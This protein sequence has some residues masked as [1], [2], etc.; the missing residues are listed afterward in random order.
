M[1]EEKRLNKYHPAVMRKNGLSG[2]AVNEENADNL[3]ECTQEALVMAGELADKVFE[4]YCQLN[5]I[6]PDEEKR[7]HF[8]RGFICGAQQAFAALTGETWEE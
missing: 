5:S 8:I 6:L 3:P 7:K 2:I 4:D 1:S